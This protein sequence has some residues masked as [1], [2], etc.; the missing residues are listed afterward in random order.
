MRR[1]DGDCD[2]ADSCHGIG[3]SLL[4][5]FG[6]EPV[7]SN[8]RHHKFAVIVTRLGVLSGKKEQEL[9]KSGC[10]DDAAEPCSPLRCRGRCW[11]TPGR[12]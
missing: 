9:T 10:G 4:I 6:Y 1:I 3:Q 5:S 2:G 7:V 11:S 12:C 8:A